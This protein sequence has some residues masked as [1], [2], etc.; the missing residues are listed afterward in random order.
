MSL[1]ERERAISSHSCAD[2]LS[3][4]RSDPATA[5]N[6]RVSIEPMQ[7]LAKVFFHVELSAVKFRSRLSV[8][9]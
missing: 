1:P 4:G 2:S 9:H 6:G 8:I 7:P 3:Q 5:D